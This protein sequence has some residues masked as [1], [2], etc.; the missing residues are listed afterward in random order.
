[1]RIQ[2]RYQPC[3]C[4]LAGGVGFDMGNGLSCLFNL[5]GYINQYSI[6]HAVIYLMHVY[7]F[8]ESFFV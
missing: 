6:S 8:M 4:L 5:L 1:M 7:Y 2:W 3:P